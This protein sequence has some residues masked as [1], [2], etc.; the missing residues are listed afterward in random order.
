MSKHKLLKDIIKE[1]I[2]EYARGSSDATGMF[3]V[4]QHKIDWGNFYQPTAQGREFWNSLFNNNKPRY[5]HDTSRNNHDDSEERPRKGM[6]DVPENWL[7]M[8]KPSQMFYYTKTV[9]GA[10][11]RRRLHGQPLPPEMVEGW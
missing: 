9:R 5:N 4:V 3:P 8:S 11:N 1:T 6:S 7:S 2:L 10:V